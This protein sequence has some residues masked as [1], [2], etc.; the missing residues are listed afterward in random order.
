MLIYDIPS[1]VNQLVTNAHTLKNN[2]FRLSI[3][4]IWPSNTDIFI[5]DDFSPSALTDGPLQDNKQFGNIGF[6]DSH[7]SNS[8]YML[9][10]PVQDRT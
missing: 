4:G 9:A 7:T 2:K 5:D 3:T 10:V 1:T 6:S 8:I